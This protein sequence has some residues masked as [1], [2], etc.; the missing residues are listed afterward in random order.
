MSQVRSTNALPVIEVPTPCPMDWNVMT[1]DERSRFC[2]HCQR[3]VHDL[4]TMRRDEVADL[5]CR[6]AGELCVR[7][8][9]TADGA[10]RTL[11]YEPADRARRWGEWLKSGAFAV[12]CVLTVGVVTI[13]LTTPTLGRVGPRVTPPPIAPSS[14]AATPAPTTPTT[15]PPA[16]SGPI[17]PSP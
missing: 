12:L 6:E 5:L 3:H 14:G 11:D 4:S 8:E 16:G 9:R 13:P 2:A 15:P 17:A 1:G 7:F 10:V